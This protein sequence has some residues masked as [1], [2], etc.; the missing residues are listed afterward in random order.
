MITE[1]NL[2]I[3]IN[4]AELIMLLNS[5]IIFKMLALLSKIIYLRGWFK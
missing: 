5:S 1:V 3:R 4:N 2:L